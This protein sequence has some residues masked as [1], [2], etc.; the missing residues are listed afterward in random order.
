MYSLVFMSFKESIK[1]CLTAH[2][3]G[4]ALRRALLLHDHNLSNYETN[5]ITAKIFEGAKVFL[6]VLF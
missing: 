5:R 4:N 6:I 1:D 2:C 3:K